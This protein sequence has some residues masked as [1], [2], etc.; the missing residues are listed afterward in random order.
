M[1]SGAIP[2]VLVALIVY[3]RVHRISFL[4]LC[5]S[6]APFAALMEAIGHLGCF[7]GGCCHGYVTKMPW[8]VA[9]PPYSY[10][11]EDQLAQGLI[12]K[13]AAASLPVHPT[14]LCNAGVFLFIF[15]LL[16]LFALRTERRGYCFLAY[17]F[18]HGMVRLLLQFY[19]G[20]P[21]PTLIGIRVPQI[22]SFVLCCAV[23][24]AF[25]FLRRKYQQVGGNPQEEIA[26]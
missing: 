8:A 5:D 17:L 24:A 21:F 22:V 18:T 9:F 11:F 20:D 4:Q 23:I 7:L 25:L 6:L 19:R 1:S 2:A 10:A 12:A 13:S 3:A 16:L 15:P 26:R 14:Q